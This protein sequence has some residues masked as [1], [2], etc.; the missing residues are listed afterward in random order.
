VSWALL[1]LLLLGTAVYVTGVFTPASQD[2]PA[3]I[4]SAALVRPNDA[5][6][7]SPD[8]QPHAKDLPARVH[9]GANNPAQGQLA[10]SQT[11]EG[12]ISDELSASS[13][14]APSDGLLEPTNDSWGELKRG[15]PVHSG[16]S[17]SSPILGYGAAGTEMPLLERRL[18]WVRVRDPAT[19]R[20]GWI[21]EEHVLTKEG[22]SGLAAAATEEE[23][24]S[25][26]DIDV[27]EIEQ[28][29]RS[30]KA[31][32]RKHYVKKRWRKPLRFVR[33]FRRF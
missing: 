28:P 4:Q 22:P 25:E 13:T 2:C 8:P 17:V 16:P 7:A 1:C 27:S 9:A 30:F 23:T 15:A 12:Q 18:G 5:K 29:K 19:S 6:Q 24:T 20:E 31:K 14:T 3:P 10:P 26:S 11:P 32:P 21:Y 33:R